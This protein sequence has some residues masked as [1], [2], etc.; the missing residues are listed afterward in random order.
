MNKITTNDVDPDS[1]SKDDDES[2]IDDDGDEKINHDE[3]TEAQGDD[4]NEH[5]TKDVVPEAEDNSEN[6]AEKPAF[7]SCE[8]SPRQCSNKND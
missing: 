4:C 7:N 8:T 1:K 3:E 2:V 5:M 6:R